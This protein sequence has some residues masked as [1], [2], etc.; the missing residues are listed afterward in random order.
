M[1]WYDGVMAGGLTPQQR[2]ICELPDVNFRAGLVNSKGQQ[3]GVDS[4][5]VTDLFEL[6]SN[7]AITDAALVT[8]DSDL[9]IGIELA[10]KKGVRIAVL[11][12]EDHTVRVSSG[13]SREIT[14]RADRVLRFGG[15]D[16]APTMKYAPRI[17]ITVTSPQTGT[18]PVKTVALPVSA[19]TPK[20]PTP[21]LSATDKAAIDNAV[22]AFIT[23]NPPPSGV[24][25]TSTK[26]IDASVDRV[27]IHH[28]LTSLAH[29]ALTGAEKIYARECYRAQLSP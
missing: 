10:Q 20:N 19:G 23:A 15:A 14:D 18:A 25:D 2:A 4:L 29:G 12:L 11:G 3:K 26:R 24:V 9:A 28:V 7:R 5:I 1:Y 21:T 27:L 8:G 22:K 16:L 6:A 17:A 13:Q